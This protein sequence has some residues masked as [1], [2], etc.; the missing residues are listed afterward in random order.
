[1]VAVVVLLGEWWSN[2]KDV[3]G[4]VDP[5]SS[6]PSMDKVS[7]GMVSGTLPLPH[8]MVEVWWMGV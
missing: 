8:H 2:G 4:V 6:V 7:V 1:M 5:L 3:D